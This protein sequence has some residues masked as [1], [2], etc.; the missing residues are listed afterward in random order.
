V[1][2]L[3]Y[4]GVVRWF[5]GYPDQALAASRRALAVARKIDD[6]FS[7]SYALTMACMVPVARAEV[8]QTLVLAASASETTADARFPGLAGWSAFLQGWARG[9]AGDFAA[10]VARMR[11]A[12]AMLDRVGARTSQTFL[13]TLLA[14]VYARM[15]RPAEG[16]AALRDGL[17]LAR[18]TGERFLEAEMLRRTGELELL[19]AAEAP[20]KRATVLVARA[21]RR[22]RGGLRLARRQQARSLELRAATSLARLLGRRGAGAAGRRILHEAHAWFREGFDSRDLRDARTLLD[23]LGASA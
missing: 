13:H 18:A 20:R 4:L 15:G 3:A 2:C 6:P 19:L 14:S 23:E 22:F 11:E 10:G 17:A 8:Q 7:L 5:L 1:S 12:L 21:E 16:L 9:E